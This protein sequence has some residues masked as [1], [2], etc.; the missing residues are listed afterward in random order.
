M[1]NSLRQPFGVT[2]SGELAE[3][4][5]LDNGTLRCSVLTYGAILQSLLVPHRNGC[6]VDVVLGLD[7]LESYLTD[8]GYMGAVVGRF[9]NRI[10]A[11]RFTLDG[12][13]YAL[14]VNNGPNHLH[15]G[16]VGF[17][18]RVWTVVD[19][20]DTHVTLSLFSPDDEEGYPGNLHVTVT[21]RLE[22][23]ALAIRYQAET[24]RATPCNLTN[25]SYFNLSGHDSGSAMEQ[26]ITLYASRYTPSDSRC[27]V[28][29][30]VEPVNETPMDLRSPT[31]I[32]SRMDSSFEQLRKGFDHNFAIDNADG[33][34]RTAALA[35][36]NT[37]G[38][39]MTVETDQ[40]GIQFYTANSAPSTPGK[41]GAEYGKHHAFCLETQGFPDAPNHPDF[42]DSILRPGQQYDHTTRFC[43]SSAK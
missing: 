11:G 4:I 37:T 29:G 16:K 22:D 36:S 38:I 6:P 33:T 25:H 8:R 13:E 26:Q 14:T 7:T 32:G 35:S 12:K 41:G 19:C 20:S 5:I 1:T 28:L 39:T 15:G 2:P 27:M 3:R 21:Y 23:N 18:R 9:A 17:S 30:T 42:P 40:P 24:D 10:A 34:L 31:V 43:F